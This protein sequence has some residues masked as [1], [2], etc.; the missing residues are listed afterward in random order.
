MA[1]GITVEGMEALA[2]AL[3]DRMELL[4]DYLP[5]RQQDHRLRSRADQGAGGRPGLDEPGVP[6]GVL[7]ERGRRR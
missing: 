1:E 2:P 4:L 5:P 6:G 7:G 3:T